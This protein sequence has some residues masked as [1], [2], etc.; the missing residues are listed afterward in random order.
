MPQFHDLP[1]PLP[2]SE[3]LLKMM[4]VVCFLL[5]IIFVE[6]M[7]GSSLLCTYFEWLGF[8]QKNKFFDQVAFEIA[9]SITVN[10]SMAVV[11]GVGPLLMVNVTYTI[12]FYSSSV[13]IGN[14]WILVIPMAISAFLLTYLHQYAWEYFSKHKLIHISIIAL[15][16][17][18]FLIIPFFF[19]TNTNLMWYP[20]LW[21][22]IHGFFSA[23]MFPNIIARYFFFISTT[24]T[25]TGLFLIWHFK[26]IAKNDEFDFV[27]EINKSNFF[28]KITK[29]IF[30]GMIFQSIFG[31]F[32]IFSARA[33]GL[34]SN[35]IPYLF[36]TII[37]FMF[38]FLIIAK[39]AS[40]QK[41]LSKKQFNFVITMLLFSI[42]GGGTLRHFYRENSLAP[43][44]KNMKINTDNYINKTKEAKKLYGEQ[45]YKY[46]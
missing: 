17:L 24:F 15:A 11:L 42:F 34:N 46:E 25:V 44:I 33:E 36:V 35:L 30:I 14:A 31:L 39:S 3:I 2:G 8:K 45:D 20:N 32:T 7:V 37:F 21:D 9:K 26:K 41:E 16:T 40:Q 23:L 43:H 28:L 18:H 29:I 6:M 19:L 38:P 12:F 22:Q 13:L 10:K 4:L 1:L 27:S 5:H